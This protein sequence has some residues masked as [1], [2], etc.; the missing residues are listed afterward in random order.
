MGE[1]Y[2]GY[3]Q[4]S[5]GLLTSEIRWEYLVNILYQVLHA[6]FHVE[7]IIIIKKS[8]NRSLMQVISNPTDHMLDVTEN[9]VVATRWHL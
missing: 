1:I 8:V 2:I 7:D 4:S 9:A 5:S 6:H 3:N